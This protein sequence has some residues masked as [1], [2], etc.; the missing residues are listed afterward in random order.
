VTKEFLS[1]LHFAQP[2]F[3][4]FLL[5]LPLLWLRLRLRALAVVLWRSLIFALLVF[6]LA[7]PQ[8]VSEATRKGERV[9]AFDLSRSIPMAMRLWA[10]RSAKQGL[11]AES[12]DR[13][14]VFGGEVKEVTD[15]DRWV[16]G[17][18][19]S[20]PIKPEQTNLEAL[21][22]TLLQL[23][24]GPRAVFLF[25]DGWETQGA[26]E[27]LLPSL[28]LSGLKIFP[29]L[30]PGPTEVSNVAVKKVLAPHQ[31]KSGEGIYL[32]VIVENHNAREVDGSLTL[33]VNGRP[34]KSEA[35][36][37][38][39][40]SHI[41][42]YQATLPEGPMVSW[43]A[44]FSASSAGSDGFLLDN[45]AASW[46]A[47][48]SKEKALVL[49]GRA[50]EGRYLQEILRRR[51][52][53]VTSV[54]LD[55]SP[56][57]PSGYGVVV[58]NNVE[59]EKFSA[60]YLAQI[61]RHVAAGNA[62]LMLGGEGSFGPGG[63]RNTPIEALL[64][65]ELTEPKK[66]EEK[67]RAVVLVID[68]S[69]SMR[70]ENKLL[71][72]KEAAKAVA[73]ELKDRD[74]LGVVGFDVEAFVV[75]PLAPLETIRGSFAS[76]VDR[77][78][79]GGRTYLYPAIAEAKRQLERQGANRKHVIILSDGETG[80][81]GSDYVDLVAV[82][83]NELKM[84]IS[85]VAIGDQANVPLLKRIA[86]YGGGFFHHTYDPAT[87]PQIV[88]QQIQEKPQEEPLVERD[89]T[90]VAVGGS[91]LLAGLPQK[92]YPSLRGYIETELKK[93]A[94][95][96]LMIPGKGRRSPLLAS[97]NYG[98]GKAVAF[99]TDLHGRWS[100]EWLQW[101]ALEKFWGRVLEWLRP[102]KEPFPP[103]EVRI[104][105]LGNHPVVDL[106][107]YGEEN[108]GSLFR[109]TFSGKAGVGEGLFRRL[110][111]GRYQA[112]LPFSVPGDYRIDLTEE[113]QGQK[114]SYPPL[115]YTLAFDPRIE[116]PQDDF[117]LSLLEQ[118]ARSTAGTV[119]PE[120]EKK[121]R[122]QEVIRTGQSL[123]FPLVFVALN[124]FLLEIILRRVFAH[125]LHLAF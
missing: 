25:T 22:S 92:T 23:P 12:S 7:D 112:T 38:K 48:Q 95:L 60:G 73:G 100:R 109:Y 110:A 46:V 55:K 75:V 83:K 52:F 82:M 115:G 49:N 5:F 32:R 105:L 121:P 36:R 74:L 10:E 99:T 24:A 114:L 62:F 78:K 119:N 27:R 9:F 113:R 104:N 2:L 68:K 43:S 94:H 33:S 41:F 40:G 69:G 97:W 64:P 11:T 65:V 77:L 56:P 37:V 124:L 91:E 108:D 15:W 21:F 39:P 117:N 3:F 54:A 59:K 34:F 96:D 125:P 66:K 53:E 122:H 57:A 123:R 103:H 63:Y 19:S 118:L 88:L 67:N 31:G 80:G 26:V 76:Q 18:V 8:L 71:Y 50:A 17:E 51:G 44:S 84:T 30:P 4:L 6:A 102:P 79:A 89:F 58:F 70:E 93:G 35:I 81:S 61:E 98:N 72:A 29:L 28:A 45:Q 42:A 20:S 106:Y 86:Q 1:Q 13:T 120:G 47:V 16:R 101:E 90:P 116:M 87:L 111:P 85:S 107:L 14:F